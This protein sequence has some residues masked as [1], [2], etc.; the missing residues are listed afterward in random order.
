MHT[1]LDI[2]DLSYT[3]QTPE[4]ETPALSHI[5]LTVDKGEFIAV[6][7]VAAENPRSFPSYPDF[8]HQVTAPS[9]SMG[10]VWGICFRKII[11]LSGAA[12]IKI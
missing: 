10:R 11:Y 1:L 12:S 9:H 2:H 5:S 7:Q 6:V 4:G 8:F 3:Y